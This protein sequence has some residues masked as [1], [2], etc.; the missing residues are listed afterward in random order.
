MVMLRCEGNKVLAHV[1]E[2]SNFSHTG[3]ERVSMPLEVRPDSQMELKGMDIGA[4]DATSY[5]C[6]LWPVLVHWSITV[7]FDTSKARNSGA[8]EMFRNA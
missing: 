4:S 5:P 3:L 7:T 8:V 1:R 6:S 2:I